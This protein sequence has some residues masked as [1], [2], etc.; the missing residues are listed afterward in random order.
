MY[1]PTNSAQG[2]LFSHILGKI[3]L[4]CLWW[5]QFK[6]MWG[7]THCVFDLHFPDDYWCWALFHGFV[8]HLYVVFGKMFIQFCPLSNQVFIVFAIE[9]S[10]LYILNI[11]PLSDVWFVD[12]FSHSVG[13]LFILFPF[14]LKTFLVWCSPTCSFLF[15]LSL[16]FLSNPKNHYQDLCWGAYHLCFLLEVL[17]FQVLN[18]SL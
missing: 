17:W 11:S 14:L 3:Y 13:C 18:L 10:S 16:L 8:G 7:D 6:Q 1:I 9:L 5:Q 12:I 15:L 4:L 2:S